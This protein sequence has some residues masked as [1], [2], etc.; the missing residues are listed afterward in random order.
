[1]AQVTDQV[2]H[3]LINDT[4]KD[5]F[6]QLSPPQRKRFRAKFEYLENGLWDTGLKVKKLKGTSSKTIFEGRLDRGNRILFTLGRDRIAGEDA[7]LIYVWAI[8]VHDDIDKK[9]RIIAPQG[10]PFLQFNAYREELHESLELEDLDAAYITQERI[11]DPIAEE[12]AG[13]RWH[14]LAEP[15]WQRLERYS[16]DDFALFLFLTPIQRDILRS[17]PPLL[18][19]GTAGSG[20]TT[21]AVYYLFK[22]VLRHQKKLF[23]TYN[24]RLRDFSQGLFKALINEHP[25]S[26]DWH[27]PDFHTFKDF[28][29]SICRHFNQPFPPEKEV[30]F[31]RFQKMYGEGQSGAR[32]DAAL[33]WEEIRA[34]IKGALP[35]A[36]LE[37]LR[38]CHRRLGEG[39]LNQDQILRLQDQ[40]RQFAKLASTKP[41]A[42]AARKRFGESLNRFAVN[43]PQHLAQHPDRVA[44]LLDQA[45]QYLESR[46][47]LTTHRYLSLYEY[48]SQ[49]RKKAPNF[50]FDRKEIYHI[51]LW[52]QKQLDRNGLWD[53]LDLVH[54][55]GRLLAERATDAFRY[56]FIICDEIQD[57]TDIQQE[58]LFGLA[59][60]PYNLFLC[61][62][63]RQIIN[64]SGFRWEELRRHFFERDLKVPEPRFLS[65]NFRSSGNIVELANS[66]LTLKETIFGSRKD[67][68]SED[69]KFKGRPPMV[70]TG[71][72]D[73]AMLATVRRA[74]A[75]RTILV[76]TEAEQRRLMKLLETELVFT[77]REAK[78]LEFDTVL[79]WKFGADPLTLDIWQAILQGKEV[80]RHEAKIRHEMNLLYVGITRAKKDLLIYEGQAGSAIWDAPEF[81][82]QIFR[83]DDQERIAQVWDVV[84]TPEEWATQARY[85]LDQEHFKAAMECFKNANDP[86]GLALA[87]ARL[88]EH[89]GEWREAAENYV[90]LGMDREAA[91]HFE[92][93]GAFDQAFPLWTQLGETERA[94]R[95]EVE[96][97][98]GDRH[99]KQAAEHLVA[100][101]EPQRAATLFLQAKQFAAAGRLFRDALN[102]PEDAASAFEKA[103]ELLEAAPLLE[104]LGHKERAAYCFLRGKD[105][106]SAAALYHELGDTGSQIKA[107]K[108]GNHKRELMELCAQRRDFEDAVKYA[109]QLDKHWLGTFADRELATGDPFKAAVGFSALNDYARAGE[110]YLKL[111]HYEAAAHAFATARDI[112][113][114]CEAFAL[115]DPSMA[116]YRA[117]NW[118]EDLEAGS[119]HLKKY[120]KLLHEKD[121]KEL[122]EQAIGLFVDHKY[123]PAVYAMEL[124]GGPGLELGI[125]YAALDREQ[126]AIQV[127]KNVSLRDFSQL[128]TLDLKQNDK[129]GFFVEF[130]LYH[131]PWDEQ[132]GGY[133]EDS[134]ATVYHQKIV[135]LIDTWLEKHGSVAAFARWGDILIHYAEM[136][137]F[138]QSIVRATVTGHCT[139]LLEPYLDNLDQ[140]HP[141]TAKKA[142]Q[143][144]QTQSKKAKDSDQHNPP[145][146]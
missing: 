36:N 115:F 39:N 34:I 9:S 130:M 7:L 88:H 46:K 101:H 127:W 87:A 81:A 62:D 86:N 3:V 42:E 141:R 143:A 52:Y 134:L 96:L 100:L 114:S 33:V 65:M 110:A 53:E 18:V 76:R 63:S 128:L 4:V 85:F 84:S 24:R 19:S 111:E 135:S 82:E 71:L 93:A 123:I 69:W 112:R 99:L 140:S 61:G 49:G 15:E 43:L 121:P 13:Q 45:R 70:V 44:D 90:H 109:G 144:Y 37:I 118:S 139:D 38:T 67:E 51:F 136:G 122:H 2:I 74:G 79:L 29:L 6:L 40:F 26:G 146:E 14:T 28:C 129:V 102:Q 77:I 32:H 54:A 106:L 80:D 47:D 116:V 10:V 66:L 113:R 23:I 35:Q 55:T 89:R 57:L 16:R 59:R 126:E 58:L 50:R 119:P 48:E 27:A 60:N 142:R 107:L 133:M 1:M 56:D 91:I 124:Q 5:Y 108:Q 41:I 78:G 97:L 75:N 30:H 132:T 95:C 25:E 104:A 145:P 68:R 92:R 17:P 12:T 103:G 72:D 21:L 98:I 125:G 138:W 22:D 105:F 73:G 83:T 11:T 120:L 64:P 117:S 94:M 31:G 8:V 131:Y 137:A 20:K